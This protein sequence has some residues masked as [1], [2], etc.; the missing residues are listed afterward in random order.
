[1]SIVS[2]ESLRCTVTCSREK[3]NVEPRPSSDSYENVKLKFTKHGRYKL[4]ESD[5]LNTVKYCWN[6]NATTIEEC[7][8]E[9]FLQ[10]VSW[11]FNIAEIFIFK[12]SHRCSPKCEIT[13]PRIVAL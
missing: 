1:M 3:R 5:Q 13:P 4:I 8:Q 7:R 6:C 2:T 10:T 11:G 12:D 9:G